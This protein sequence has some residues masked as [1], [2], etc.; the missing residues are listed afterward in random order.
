MIFPM[1]TQSTPCAH[2]YKYVK[3]T[4]TLNRR[5]VCR[6]SC[7]WDSS[8]C[9]GWLDSTPDAIGQMHIR[10]EHAPCECGR[11]YAAHFA[12]AVTD[13][14]GEGARLEGIR[15]VPC[16]SRLDNPR[17][18]PLRHLLACD[19]LECVSGRVTADLRALRAS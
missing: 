10:V 16:A 9:I 2:G 4:K 13:F 7:Q 11:N 5:H 18:W 12:S 3:G 17:G 15:F 1:R 6:P 14:R 8:D 19:C